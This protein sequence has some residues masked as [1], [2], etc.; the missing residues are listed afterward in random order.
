MKYLNLGCG[1]H[2]SI[3]KEWVNV[4]FVSNSA[5]VLAHNLL[6]GIPFGDNQFDL[7]YHSHVLEHFSKEDGVLL[8]KECFRVLKPGGVLR[9]AIPNLEVIAKEYLRF[10]E[11]GLE[12]PEDAIVEANYEWMKI[13]MIDQ[14][15]RNK[16]GGK[17]IAYLYQDELINQDFV[18][19]RIGVEGKAIRENYLKRNNE[20]VEKSSALK[21]PFLSRLKRN[22]LNKIRTVIEQKIIPFLG[23]NMNYHEIGSFRMHGEVHQWMYDRYSLL[24]LLDNNGGSI[25]KV[26]S[27][28]ES[29][30]TDW[31]K[32]KLDGID[33]VVRKP[34][35]LFVES[36]K[37]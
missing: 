24:K 9:I 12:N 28:F 21:K 3:S 13:E 18:Y 29:F 34:D 5:H 10:L 26:T 6:E 2:Y 11:E 1:S 25:S 22:I 15:A 31:N 20:M 4:D 37:K 27:A 30:I 23:V 7:V 19:H 14:I 32:Y 36:I 16:S 35:S 17:M 8:I 33:G